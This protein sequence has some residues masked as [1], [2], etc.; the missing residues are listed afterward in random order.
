M[1][2]R[3]LHYCIIKVLSDYKNCCRKQYVGA[4]HTVLCHVCDPKRTEIVIAN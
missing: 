2:Y 1:Q 3:S 4:M